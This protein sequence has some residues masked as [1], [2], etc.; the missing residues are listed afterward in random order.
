MEEFEYSVELRVEVGN[1]SFNESV[2]I[3]LAG[4]AI[5]DYVRFPALGF[6]NVTPFRRRQTF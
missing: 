2:H 1:S 5:S 6:S 4:I 3:S